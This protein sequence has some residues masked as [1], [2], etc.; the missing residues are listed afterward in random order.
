MNKDIY[1][2]IEN[3]DLINRWSQT[4][5]YISK[6]F[7]YP[8]IHSLTSAFDQKPPNYSESLAIDILDDYEDNDIPKDRK[9]DIIAVMLEGYND[10]S[11]FEEMKFLVDV[12]KPWHDLREESV[13]G[14]LVNN[15]FAGETVDTEWGFLT[16]FSNFHQFRS[17]TNSY[18]HYFSEQGY[19]VE[20]S[21]PCYQWFYNRE[22]VNTYLGFDNYYYFENHYARLANDTIARDK[23]L[24]PEIIELLQKDKKTQ[25]PYFSFNVTYQNHG[26]Y[27]KTHTG[28][29]QYIENAFL[30]KESYNILNNYLAGIYDTNKEVDKFIDYFRDKKATVII[31]FGDHNPWLGDNNKVYHELGIN[32]D[33]DTE[34]GFF[35]YYNTPYLIW[36][37]DK[38]KEV[39]ENEFRGQGETIGPYFLM[40]E[41]FNL[42]GY[43]GNSFMKLSNE[44]KNYTSIIH[45][46]GYFLVDNN[47][48]RE[49]NDEADEV[50]ERFLISQYYLRNNFLE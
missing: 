44:I 14:E 30:S 49:L 1:Q 24:F 32:I 39:L 40:N 15:I 6:G 13:Y 2:S 19:I 34:A 48:T 43:K 3:F 38:A 17:M 5:S 41:F 50:L 35:N 46:D 29:I 23:V 18:V 10:F 22:N 16:G 27:P 36:S 31:L 11:K 4:Q 21:H 9:V 33:L 12:Y 37:N 7:V 25:S 47:L 42:A 20:G 28:E 26:P 45:R 8:F